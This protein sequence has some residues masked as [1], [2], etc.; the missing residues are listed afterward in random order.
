MRDFWLAQ[1]D[2]NTAVNGGG[3]GETQPGSRPSPLAQAGGN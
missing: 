2:L 3:V 1:S